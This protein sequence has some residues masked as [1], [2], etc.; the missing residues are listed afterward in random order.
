MA[1]DGKLLAQARTRLEA[2]KERNEQEHSRRISNV[3][4][5][6][7][8]IE[9]IDTRMRAQMGQLLRLAISH[10]AHAAESISAL[11]EENLALQQRR[12]ELLVE[13]GWSMDYLNDIY[14]CPK[15]KDSGIYNSRICSCLE[16]LYNE[17]LS[18]E[19]G[20][21]MKNGCESFD[22]FDIDLYSSAFDPVLNCSP[23]DCMEKVYNVCLRFA[24]LFPQKQVN[25]L[26]QGGTGL[27]KTFLSACIAREVS[28][29]GCSVCYQPVS[30]ALEAFETQKFGSS[31]SSEQAGRLVGRMLECDLLILDDLGTEMLT[32]ISMSALYTLINTRL[33]NGKSMIIS[34]NLGNDAISKRYSAQISSRLLGEFTTLPFV[35]ADIRM[36]KNRR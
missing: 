35:G 10:D 17:E 14:S 16:T 12:A 1:H 33:V 32:T 4:A 13:N 2:R 3:Y 27:G 36:L 5:R 7:P 29:K 15:C 31:D 20:T 34:T 6:V 26:F 25:L 23:R 8:E 19:L 18:R 11:R 22:S 21:L 30:S 28:K 24:R 9:S